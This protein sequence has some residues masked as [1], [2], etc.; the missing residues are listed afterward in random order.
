MNKDQ[1][2]VFKVIGDVLPSR[3]STLYKKLI[4]TTNNTYLQTMVGIFTSKARE[5]PGLSNLTLGFLGQIFPKTFCKEVARD[6]DIYR[7]DF[8]DLVSVCFQN[9]KIHLSSLINKGVKELSCLFAN[10]KEYGATYLY[11]TFNLFA[12]TYYFEEIGCIIQE[13]GDQKLMKCEELINNLK[14]EK[15]K[16]IP[17]LCE[18]FENFSFFSTGKNWA[19][20][21]AIFLTGMVVRKVAATQQRELG[22]DPFYEKLDGLKLSTRKIKRLFPEAIGKLIE[23]N[24]NYPEVKS[25]ETLA[26]YYF[27]NDFDNMANEDISFTFAMGLSFR[28]KLL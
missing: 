21:R 10:R 12:L 25:I 7:Q 16:I 6:K 15:S 17:E 3:L 20:K 4:E 22:S 19:C 5:P 28:H 23:Y 26:S 9:S 27:M 8:L 2:D 11:F 13:N 18:M 14:L 1:F 24:A